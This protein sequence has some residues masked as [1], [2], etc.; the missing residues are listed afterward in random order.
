MVSTKFL[1]RK[2]WLQA[3]TVFS[4]HARGRGQRGRF[5]LESRARLVGGAV[6]EAQPPRDLARRAR[7]TWLAEGGGV[8]DLEGSDCAAEAA[9]GRLVAR[10][11]ALGVLRHARAARRA[12]RRRRSR[13]QALPTGTLCTTCCGA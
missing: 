12:L 3:G 8:G 5:G 13:A 9:A 1:T 7:C 2:T 10:P 11:P 4:V 6:P